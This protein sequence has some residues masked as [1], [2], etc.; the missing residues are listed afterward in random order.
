MS[1]KNYTNLALHDPTNEI[2]NHH[3]QNMKRM[4]LK[5]YSNSQRAQG[6]KGLLSHENS[7]QDLHKSMAKILPRREKGGRTW[8]EKRRGDEG[9]WLFFFCSFQRTVPGEGSAPFVLD[10]DATHSLLPPFL[11]FQDFF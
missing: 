4:R 6:G 9:G 10:P 7:V 1:S 8:R 3:D 11:A 2:N 5:T